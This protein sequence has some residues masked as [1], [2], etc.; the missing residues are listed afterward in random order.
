MNISSNVIKNRDI[1]SIIDAMLGLSEH[2]SMLLICKLYHKNNIKKYISYIKKILKE[3]EKNCKKHW[4]YHIKQPDQLW[5]FHELSKRTFNNLE[6]L[7]KSLFVWEDRCNVWKISQND[8][9][10]IKIANDIMIRG[11]HPQLGKVQYWRHETKSRG[12]GQTYI[13]WYEN[14]KKKTCQAS[15]ISK[16]LV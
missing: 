7:K 2:N 14:N 15:K 4:N 6:N 11:Y 12:A 13:I 16:V 8:H 10:R 1:R 3:K 5:E 9:Y